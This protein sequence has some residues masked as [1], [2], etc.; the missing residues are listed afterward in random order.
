MASVTLGSL[1]SGDPPL[2]PS[3]LS[4]EAPGLTAR[5]RKVHSHC[6]LAGRP[7]CLL[8]SQQPGSHPA[9]TPTGSQAAAW[10]PACRPPPHSSMTLGAPL[11]SPSPAFL[12]RF[13]L[14][15]SDPYC[16]AWKALHPWPLAQPS[17][18]SFRPLPR[19][20]LLSQPLTPMGLGLLWGGA[21]IGFVLHRRTAP[22]VFQAQ[23]G[24]R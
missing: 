5:V 3:P 15:D 24:S 7:S 2:G 22:G 14:Y 16:S 9:P 1:L 12:P 10:A 11:T 19:G 20:H 6:V 23:S 8:A 18:S 13:P 21:S 4:R 17:L